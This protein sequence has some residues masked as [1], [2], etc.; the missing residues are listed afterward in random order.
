MKKLFI[1]LISLTVGIISA[2]AQQTP[3]PPPA[4]PPA[5]QNAAN[6][7]PNAPEFKFKSGDTYDFGEVP[8]GP[9]AEHKFEF[10]NT[11]KEPLVIMNASASCGCTTP[12]WS[13]EPVMPGKKGI[14][15]VKY[16]TQGRVGPFRKD[17]FIQSNAKTEAGKE[18]YEI[19]ITGTVKAKAPEAPAA[20]PAKQ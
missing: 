4:A 20:T 9:I 3:P 11:G 13:K 1:V 15:T 16:N 12:E 10:T 7:N 5:P 6:A 19:H 18:R 8:E 17:I 2:Q 14:V